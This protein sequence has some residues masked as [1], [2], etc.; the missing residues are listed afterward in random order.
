MEKFR[1]PKNGINEFSKIS[2]HDENL[3]TAQNVK[4]F[5]FDDLV[6]F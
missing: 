2:N 4:N 5:A 3:Q 1:S 6:N